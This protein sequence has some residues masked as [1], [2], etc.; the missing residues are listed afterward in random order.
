MKKKFTLKTQVFTFILLVFSFTITQAQDIAINEV[1]SSNNTAIADEDGDFSDWIELYNYG[2]TSVNLQDFGLSD[3]ATIPFKW[4]F[5]SFTLAPNAYVLIWASDKD[6]VTAGQPLHTNFKISSGGE[7]IL[8]TN[9]QAVLVDESPAVALDPDVSYGRQPNGT[10][11]W[12]YFYTST[13]GASNT[14]TGLPELL[15]PPT[16]S[17]ASGLY[18][19]AFNLTISHA[20]PT[21]VI[22]Y[23]L[24]GSEPLIDN[25]T[26]TNFN[27]KNEYPIDIG[28]PLGPMLTDSYNSAIYTQAINIHDRSA[29]PDQV[30]IK[31]TNQ[32]PLYIPINPVR[33]ATVIKAR[34]YVSGIASKIAAETF[35]VWSGGNPYDI[36]VL[37]LQ[38]QENLLFGYNEGIYTSGIDF[39]TWRLANPNSPQSFRPEWNNYWRSGSDWEYPVNIEIFEPNGTE[40]N[41]TL[42][43]NGGMRIH[44]N[45][46]RKRAIKNLRFYARSEYDEESVFVHNLFDEPIPGA[47][48]PD[49]N[50]FKRILLRGDGT[51]GPV[52]YDVVFNRTMQPIFNGVTRIQ[53]VIHFINGE[54]W[55]LNAVRDR[56]DD[57]HYALNF[58]LDNDNVVIIDCKGVNCELD[59]GNNDDYLAYIAMRDF[60][61][62]NDMANQTQ[63]NQAADMLDMVS[64]IDHFVLEIF[65]AN[66]SYERDFWKAREPVNDGYGDGKW[67]VSVQDF[68]ASLKDNTN[69]LEFYSDITSGS[70]NNILLGNLLVNESFKNQ[71][72]NRFADVLN[73]VFTPAYFNNVVNET[74]D[75]IEPYLTENTNRHPRVDF[76]EPV[77]KV[78]LLDWG[79][80]RPAAQRDQIKDYFAISNV[81]NIDLNVSSSEAGMVKISTITIDSSTPGIPEDPYPWTGKYFQGIPLTLEAI[82]LPGFEFSHWSGSVSGTDPILEVTPTGNMQIQANFEAGATPPEVVYFWLMDSEIPNDTPLEYLDATYASNSLVSSIMYESCLEGYPFTNGDPNWRRA[83]FERK[84]SPTPLNYRPEANND[85]PYSPDIMKGIQVKQPFRSGDLENFLEFHVPT[86]DFENIKLSFAV[87]SDGAAQSLLLDYWNGTDWSTANLTNPS[88]TITETYEIKLFDFSNVDVA[89]DNPDFII[90]MR[91][92]GTDMYAEEGKEVV[93][94]NIA[95]EG[96]STL[97]NEGIV[98]QAVL[99]VYPNPTNDIL[100]VK[101]SEPIDQIVF[102]NIYGQLVNRYSPTG[103]N[104][105]INIEAFSQG[106]YLMKVYSNQTERTLKIIKR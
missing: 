59:E 57:H 31:N 28:D 90:R 78:D 99:K 81:V 74:F 21:A 15:V 52:S 19:N 16:F 86:T 11:P 84:N 62:D 32:D 29:E 79:T 14:G 12:L 39:D 70:D 38:I 104:F 8:L 17:Q 47:T 96:E 26:G 27:Y 25:L 77:E 42:S 100:N 4:V 75:E 98:K 7:A 95:V 9:A 72:I 44:G 40:L 82:A 58:D 71:F 61:I 45:N 35:F 34:A 105:E 65:A 87:S 106:I 55:G 48:V 63:Y 68:E 46:S 10:G 56:I 60:I 89:N 30:T 66:D 3:D 51:G 1:M 20:N 83:S 43:Q 37:S 94:N 101:T 41:S 76:Y 13:P 97:S 53:P 22:V 54:Y 69:W 50:E 5:P 88:E 18:T 2:A 73:T 93:M 80:T 92:D 23:T 36:P 102:Y 33:K 49:N 67:R 24:D 103:L 6:R 85:I 64:F 91:F